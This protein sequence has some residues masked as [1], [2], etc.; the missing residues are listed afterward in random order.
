[1]DQGAQSYC[2]FINGDDNGIV[3]IIRDYKDGLILYLNS[4]V[5]NI[6]I[7]EDLVEDTFVKIVVKR[8]KFSGKSTF[9]TWLYV[10]GRNTAVDYLRRNGREIPYP[11]EKL[12]QL[13]QDEED[14]EARCIRSQQ[15]QLLHRCLKRLKSDYRSALYL[16]YFEHFKPSQAATILKKSGKQ[17]ENLMY[18]AKLSLK[19]QL[20]KEGFVYEGL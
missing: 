11:P 15:D 12:A 2:R 9:K 17:M 10:I 4:Y 14:V 19:S 1:M 3:E 5:Q 18:R 8:P 20:E 16:V 6:H 13:R 7:A